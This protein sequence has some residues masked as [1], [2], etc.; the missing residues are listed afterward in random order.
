MPLMA[1]ALIAFVAAALW[2]IWWIPIRLLDSLGFAGAWGGVLLNGGAV[3][4]VLLVMALWRVPFRI[5]RRSLIGAMLAGVAMGTYST[6]INYSDVVR[7]ILLFYLAPTWSKLI[8]WAF[9]GHRWTM[10]VSF[11]LITSLL[12]AY[13]VL[14]A[15]L[16]VSGLSF[17][18]LLALL[19]GMAWA[20]GAAFVFTGDRTSSVSLTFGAVAAGCGIGLIFA[21]FGPAIAP[22]G[23][24]TN[25]LLIGLAFG[26]LYVVPVS[27]MTLWSA[28]RLAPAVLSFL[29][30]AEILS[31]VITGA[32]FLDEPFGVLQIIG[33]VLIIAAALSEVVPRLRAQA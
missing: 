31:G 5:G 6:A 28:Q 14:G 23:N 29:L 21:L 7:V 30:T 22:Q 32:L 3:V 19:S 17:G 10:G 8:E 27:I 2:G 18:D 24:Y 11:A 12:G 9:L 26:A 20:S 1:P 4:T 16:S 15:D 25:G 13:L 33:A